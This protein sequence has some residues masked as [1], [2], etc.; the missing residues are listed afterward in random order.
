MGFSKEEKHRTRQKKAKCLA[1][2]KRYEE[3]MGHIWVGY[4]FD[5]RIIIES[6]SALEW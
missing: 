3:L 1:L 2:K 6:L 4:L 5:F